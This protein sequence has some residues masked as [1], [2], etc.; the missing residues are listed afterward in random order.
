MTWWAVHRDDKETVH[1]SS[2][3]GTEGQ[4]ELEQILE[5]SVTKVIHQMCCDSAVSCGLCGFIQ[6]LNSQM[7]PVMT[8]QLANLRGP[9]TIAPWSSAPVEKKGT[10]SR[11]SKGDSED[12]FQMCE[13]KEGSCSLPK[14][15]PVFPCQR[16]LTWESTF[17]ASKN[18]GSCLGWCFRSSISW[19]M[20][21]T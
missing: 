9:S 3:Q 1:F 18:N 6:I 8:G 19:Q 7:K 15:Q 10:Q 12:A 13:D 17:L 11:R 4:N 16:I 14:K 2:V 5:S 21:C 20:R